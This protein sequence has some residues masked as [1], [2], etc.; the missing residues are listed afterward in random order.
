MAGV[1]KMSANVSGS[2][3]KR[4]Q[5]EIPLDSIHSKASAEK[6]QGSSDQQF[7]GKG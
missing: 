4:G 7:G 6:S 5:N 2:L 3:K 1:I